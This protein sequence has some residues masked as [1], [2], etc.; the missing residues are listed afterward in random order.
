MPASAQATA[1][2]TAPYNPSRSVRARARIPCWAAP[3]AR[4]AGLATP[5]R[6]E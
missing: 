3:A 2:L 5:Y 6:S 1:C 4:A